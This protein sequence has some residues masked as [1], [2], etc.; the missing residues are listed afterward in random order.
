MTI[1]SCGGSGR[2]RRRSSSTGNSRLSL[3][4]GWA[5]S[6]DISGRLYGWTTAPAPRPDPHGWWQPGCAP[7]RT[8][9]LPTRQH[10]R[11][12]T[13]AAI[14]NIARGRGLAASD[15]NVL[16]MTRSLSRSW[17][18]PMEPGVRNGC[19][20]S[21]DGSTGSAEPVEGLAGRMRVTGGERSHR[22]RWLSLS[23]AAFAGERR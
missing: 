5:G 12:G 8:V 17:P 22:A 13:L 2:A 18:E 16:T 15:Q 10:S 20:A 11:A 14:E 3:W 4:R 19:V 7:G 6:A 23:A 21:A 9:S 1:S